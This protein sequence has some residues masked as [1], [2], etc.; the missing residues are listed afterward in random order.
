MEQYGGSLLGERGGLNDM[1]DDPS[2]GVLG[3]GVSDGAFIFDCD[4]G[5]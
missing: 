4:V 5:N 2:S 3:L 1:D